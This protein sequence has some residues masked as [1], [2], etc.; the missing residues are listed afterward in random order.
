MFIAIIKF[1]LVGLRM[2]DHLFKKRKRGACREGR[3]GRGVHGGA[4]MEGR[5]GRGVKGGA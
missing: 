4:C 2:K 5:V 3:E 1:F